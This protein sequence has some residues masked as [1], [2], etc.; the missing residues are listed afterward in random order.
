MVK[1]TSA[2]DT[3][4]FTSSAMTW[5]TLRSA[6]PTLM[7]KADTPLPA[8]AAGASSGTRMPSFSDL[9]KAATTLPR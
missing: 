8:A 7:E 9:K 1:T 4:R 5:P 3:M 6:E 2:N